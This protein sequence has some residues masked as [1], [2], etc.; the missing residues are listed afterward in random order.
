MRTRSLKRAFT[1]VELLVVIA[2]LAILI[3]ILLPATSKARRAAQR[4][5][6]MNNLR[7][8]GISLLGY[9]LENRH[10][11]PLGSYTTHQDNYWVDN[12]FG[13]NTFRPLYKRG[14]MKQPL[15]WYCPALANAEQARHGYNTELNPWPPSMPGKLTR[16]S[17]GSRVTFK[18]N[19][20]KT[21]RVNTWRGV[22]FAPNAVRLTELKQQV[23]M[24]DVVSSSNSVNIRHKD[25]VNALISDGSVSYKPLS[26]VSKHLKSIVP[27]SF[28]A[29]NDI[30]IDRMFE[31]LD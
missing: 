16:I 30:H 19:D 21:K 31:A 18:L 26:L 1:L 27:G 12:G 9:G 20:G 2:V 11:L 7:Q 10:F 25:G 17:Y 23:I 15:I 22:D 14:Y 28:D 5:V 3:S 8:V 13:I 4:T 6:C 24:V 29:A